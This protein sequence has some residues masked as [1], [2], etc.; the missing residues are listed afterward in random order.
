ME[1]IGLVVAKGGFALPRPFALNQQRG[2]RISRQFAGEIQTRAPLQPRRGALNRALKPA[3]RRDMRVHTKS[4]PKSAVDFEPARL[5]S[6]RKR[7]GHE[8]MQ[9]RE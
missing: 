8:L 9:R 1:G 7:S 5:E 4:D 2:L 3:T 6:D